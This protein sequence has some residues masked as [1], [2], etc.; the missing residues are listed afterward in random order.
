MV[1]PPSA[2]PVA[3]AYLYAEII[4]GHAARLKKARARGAQ[5]LGPAQVADYVTRQEVDLRRETAGTGVEVIR[6]GDR[7]LL[8]LPA[9]LTFDVGRAEIRPQ[10]RSTLTEIALKLKTYKQSFVDVLGHTDST[11][12]AASNQALSQRR[13]QSVANHLSAN[14]VNPVRI[15][16]RGYG[17]S[18]P[19]ADNA[20]DA[21]RAINRRVEIKLVPLR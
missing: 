20:T 4:G 19:I 3:P 2:G 14:G 1:M 5:P 18:E 17:S 15:A 16:T 13:A 12:R 10:A 11:G 7:L 6:V 21:G 8:R 9:A